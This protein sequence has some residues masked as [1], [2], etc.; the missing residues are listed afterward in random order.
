MLEESVVFRH[1]EAGSRFSRFDHTDGVCVLLPFNI[2][3][4]VALAA[5]WSLLPPWITLMAA[6]MAVYF[7]RIRFPEGIAPLI[8]VLLTP[9]HLSSMAEDRVLKPYPARKRGGAGQA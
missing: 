4:L 9:H 1:L 6:A 2:H 5:G 8:H 3:Y 7:L